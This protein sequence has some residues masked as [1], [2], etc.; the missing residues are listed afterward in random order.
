MKPIAVS[1]SIKKN[2][3]SAFSNTLSYACSYIVLSTFTLMMLAWGQSVSAEEACEA[4][5]PG[6][7]QSHA[8]DGEVHLR[9]N[10]LLAGQADTT[11]VTQSLN[12][13][14][15]NDHCAGNAC[16]ASE[17]LARKI[18]VDS[19]PQVV[20]AE[21]IEVPFLETEILGTSWRNDYGRVEVTASATVEFSSNHS[22][23]LVNELI[24]RYG[25]EAKLA[26]GDYW[27]G[28]L[29]LS[30]N[31]KI[32][33]TGDGPVRIF[34]NGDLTVPSGGLINSPSYGQAGDSSRLFI[35][36]END[37]HGASQVTVSGIIYSNQS[38]RIGNSGYLFGAMSGATAT[39]GRHGNIEYQSASLATP[40]FSN[41]CGG[42]I[43]ISDIDGDG[44]ADESDPDMDGDNISNH[45]ETLVGT[46]P[47][48]VT[49]TPVDLNLNGIPDAL[50][51]NEGANVCESAFGTGL[52]SHILEVDGKESK[53][54][55]HSNAQLLGAT[56]P[57]IGFSKVKK[58]YASTIDT[59]FDSNCIA[60][61][62]TVE[63]LDPGEFKAT[64]STEKVVVAPE[65]ESTLDGSVT[66]FNKIRVRTSGSVTLEG[67]NE[68]RIK[69][70]NI[71]WG[72]TLKLAAGDYWIEKLRI[73]SDAKLE[74]LGEGTVRIFVKEAVRFHWN[75]EINI[76]PVD[77]AAKSHQLFIYS[78]DKAFIGSNV[79]FAGHIFS[80]LRT[81]LDNTAKV[82]GAITAYKAVL[83][84]DAQVIFNADSVPQIDFGFVCDIDS[85]G[86]YD[87]FDPD[88]DGDGISNDYEDQVG[89]D[90]NNASD[91]PTDV[92][93][94]GIPD[95]IDEDSD[96]DGVPNVDD[97]FPEDPTETS[98]LDNDGIGDNA[99][100]DRD[101]D[102]FSND[103]ETSQGTDPNDAA[104]T[105][106]DLDGDFIPDSVDDD[107]DGDGVL[108]T[109]DLFPTNPNESS[110]LDQDGIGDNSDLDRD[111]DGISNAYETQVG[112]DPNDPASRP[113]D[114][115]GDGI[116]DTVDS[117][118]D[119]DGVLNESDA[120]PDNANES[121]DLDGDGIGDNTDPDRDGDGISNSYEEQVGTN[122][123]SAASTPSDIE[124][125]GIP[126]SLDDDRDGDGVDNATDK[127]P[128]DPNESSDLDNDGIGDNAD[129][130]RDGDGIS[131]DYETQVGTDPN[132]ASS[133]PSDL[134]SDG[135]PDSIDDDRDG[136]GVA[137][138]EDLFPDDATESADL[139]GD[140]IGDN[141]DTDRDGDGISNDYETQAGTDP[142]DPANTPPDLDS[143]G[144]P[145]LF[146]DDKDGDGVPNATDAFPE[147]AT[148]T[149]DL[150]GDGLGDNTD[151]DIDGDGIS[152]DHENQLGTDPNDPTSAPADLDG[153]Q[154]PDALDND[155]DGDGVENAL[156]VFPNNAAESSDLDG[157]GIGDNADTD[158]DGDGISNDYETQVGTDPNDAAN[159]PS[160]IDGDGIPDALDSDIDGDGIPNENDLFPQNNGENSDLDGDGIGDNSDDDIDGDGVSNEDE[161]AAGTS[162]V[163]ANDFPDLIAPV[164]SID[165][166]T[167]QTVE[168]D[169]FQITGEVSDEKSGMGSFT[170]INDRYP[171]LD[172]SPLVNGLY[173]TIDVPLALGTNIINFTALDNAGN[174]VEQSLRVDRQ[175]AN[176][177]LSLAISY[178]ANSAVLTDA[179]TN[180]RA[181][182]VSEAEV[183]SLTAELVN[184]ATNTIVGVAIE[185]STT[186][187]T[188]WALSAETMDL[189]A[190]LNQLE[191]IATV[192]GAALR[193]VVSVFYQDASN[194]IPAPQ[195]IDVSPASGSYL[196]ADTVIVRGEVAAAELT[197]LTLDGQSIAFSQN[198]DNAALYYFEQSLLLPAESTSHNIELE[199]ID[200]LGQS[201]QMA[202]A[203]QQDNQAPQIAVS[204]SIAPFP[205]ANEVLTTPYVIAGQVSDDNLSLMTINGNQIDLEVTQ[206]AGEFAFEVPVN[207]DAT[208]ANIASLQAIDLAGNL[209]TLDFSLQLANS[210]TVE[211]LR[212]LNDTQLLEQADPIDLSIAARLNQLTVNH[213]VNLSIT[214]GAGVEIHAADLNLSDLL[215]TGDVQIPGAVDNYRLMLTV[216]D[217][218]DNAV[219]QTPSSIDV[220]A[221]EPTPLALSRHFPEQL[222][223]N[224]DVN[225]SIQLYFNQGI[226]ESKL[227][228]TVHE[229]FHGLTY[230][231]LDEPGTDS[232]RAQGYA[233]RQVDRDHELKQGALSLI[234]T[235]NNGQSGE[236]LVA[237]YYL[238]EK[239]AYGATVFVQVTYDN[240]PLQRFQFTTRELPTFVEGKVLDQFGN[241]VEGV[242]VAIPTLGLVTKSGNA[243][244]FTFGYQTSAE[245]NIPGGR[246]EL[247]V[248][249]QMKSPVYGSFQGMISVTEGRRNE[250][251]PIVAPQ[252]NGA[253]PF[254][255]VNSDSATPVKI[256]GNELELNLSDATLVF[257]DDQTRG[258]FHSQFTP[259]AAI[260][261]RVQPGLYLP[262]LYSQQ[263][264]GIAVEGDL[265]VSF[266]LPLYENSY[267]YAPVEG[268]LVVLI[269][270]EPISGSLT[271]VGVAE[272]QGTQIISRGETHFERLDVI[273]YSRVGLQLQEELQQY[274]DGKSSLDDV[275]VALQ[276]R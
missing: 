181:A 41:I 187:V 150:D 82:Y 186:D 253:L 142:N 49:D 81:K 106:P 79:S 102:G 153:D 95:S 160:D 215:A 107:L 26:P 217:A 52:Q 20:S 108:N 123:N 271:V 96:G 226:D 115:D 23:Y 251:G 90:P 31:A 199:A 25:S 250:L 21:N 59:C 63:K 256:N 249:A 224:V 182:L 162:P 84:A 151:T 27:V 121:S 189:V 132:D 272:R 188:Q 137:N 58:H 53:A 99:D 133:T 196:Q 88:R 125:D 228:V 241:A 205:V 42:D 193:R 210:I 39:L 72:G 273:S 44:I 69:K 275:L 267:D 203:Y 177:T 83:N 1:N 140:G 208:G 139:D 252:L 159:V 11:I 94:D 212:P 276:N 40:E 161:Y 87:G 262:F 263:P 126:D 190:G 61:G 201:T 73:S 164:L 86:I 155:I 98:D 148:E 234:S 219:A 104:S 19:F 143:D 51:L 194:E 169:S 206:V 48:D 22:T 232:I 128:N 156:D 192:N 244:L 6:A 240:S 195:F 246:Y 254:H 110:D 260:Y 178:P 183:S 43:E 238:T 218:N 144:I 7:I 35:Y 92:D 74:V 9:K 222:A 179:Q 24:L 225:E 62:M 17:S 220:V 154:I 101:G 248:N 261:H 264:A 152:N 119:G 56:N 235:D 5:F 60:S 229:T 28:R 270:L 129:T 127:F 89:T 46:D 116:P 173:W 114:S 16:V 120:F 213:R 209:T 50:E 202:L 93:G 247:Q 75:S 147:D 163:D 47:K 184:L 14:K 4:V 145:D 221:D 243:G 171:E 8:E 37:F 38:A 170:A 268:E 10:S 55:F 274:I 136:D 122:P 237:A 66:E 231:N 172:L 57:Y 70:L 30:A 76:D 233:L 100:T 113:L 239:L 68:Y 91:T 269:G 105:P 64:A 80:V 112:T 180:V 214:N 12:A 15:A 266:N 236:V 29:K 111:G 32:T 255:Y 157:D 166:F 158:R 168:V 134:D 204:S 227:E 109:N 71:G 135:I 223:V 54:V 146:D 207:V 258:R 65:T 200:G 198:A 149:S 165:T 191:L 257:S 130:D 13:A 230:V 103:V 85:D 175:E 174:T 2:G 18:T 138:N 33:L 78:Y 259:V 97:A 124:G 117:D 197:S 167:D 185:Q 34:V 245:D 3:Y 118:R 67:A 141:A 131:N 216:F 36:T 176:V 265:Q 242:E 211:L 45:Y 77:P